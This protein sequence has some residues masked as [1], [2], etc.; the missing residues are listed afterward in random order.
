[1][2]I[3]AGPDLPPR[4]HPPTDRRRPR[5]RHLSAPRWRPRYRA[6][7]PAPPSARRPAPSLLSK[8]RL[9]TWVGAGIGRA[10]CRRGWGGGGGRIHAARAPGARRGRPG[11]GVQ[12]GPGA[13]RA[14]GPA[15]AGVPGPPPP[16]SRYGASVLRR[17]RVA[18]ELGLGLPLASEKAQISA[19]ENRPRLQQ[20]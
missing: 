12:A 16:R 15:A 2:N 10:P 5:P 19:D 20:A 7:H 8:H 1:M 6:H 3:A 9:D 14:R 17:A 18:G 13:R 4:P 11:R